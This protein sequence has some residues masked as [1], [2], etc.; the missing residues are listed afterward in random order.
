MLAFL[1]ALMSDC[2][3]VL[4][5]KIIMFQKMKFTLAYNLDLKN[6]CFVNV[7]TMNSTVIIGT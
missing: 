4:C 2:S 6:L 1:L 3:I 5:S 7:L